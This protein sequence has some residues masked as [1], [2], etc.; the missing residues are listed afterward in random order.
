MRNDRQGWPPVARKARRARITG[1]AASAEGRAGGQS[2]AGP[3]AGGSAGGPERADIRSESPGARRMGAGGRAD[4]H[5]PG[6]DPDGSWEMAMADRSSTN[7]C[8]K[9]DSGGQADTARELVRNVPGVAPAPSTSMAHWHF[10]DPGATAMDK[11]RG[12]VWR[13]RKY[14]ARRPCCYCRAGVEGKHVVCDQKAA[15]Q[16]R[17]VPRCT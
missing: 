7:G 13:A 12:R 17:R 14:V 15:H 16:V 10:E 3:C 1:K 4:G 2:P 8:S 11:R 5:V 9:A 6:R